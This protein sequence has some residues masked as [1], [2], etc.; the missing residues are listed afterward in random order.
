MHCSTQCSA[1]QGKLLCNVGQC[2]VLQ[3]TMQ[4]CSV[5][6]SV[7][8]M[9]LL[10]SMGHR[11]KKIKF[12]NFEVLQLVDYLKINSEANSNTRYVANFDI[13]FNRK[14][15]IEY[16]HKNK[17]QS[18][19][20]SVSSTWI[21]HQEEFNDLDLFEYKTNKLQTENPSKIIAGGYLEP[22]PIYTSSEYDKIGNHG[23]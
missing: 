9:T 4:C 16:F 23:R 7:L 8:Y 17:I 3:S 21:G 15:I 1:V 11:N 2:S 18:L 10:I 13:C 22:R 5:Q 12:K 20:L 19:D 6:C 14:L